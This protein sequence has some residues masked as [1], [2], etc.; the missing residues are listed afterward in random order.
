MVFF[1][2]ALIEIVPFGNYFQFSSSLQLVEHMLILVVTHV[3][4]VHHIIRVLVLQHIE[5]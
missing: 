1:K 4:F 3:L 5:E 2:I